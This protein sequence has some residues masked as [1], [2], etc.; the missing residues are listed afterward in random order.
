M[1]TTNTKFLNEKDNR[2]YYSKSDKQFMPI[3]HATKAHKILD[4]IAWSRENVHELGSNGHLDVGCKDGYFGL[5][6]ASEGISYLGI[7]PSEDA[8]EEATL[9]AAELGLDCVFQVAFIEDFDPGFK[10][11]TVSM[12]EVLEHVV[13]AEAVVK[14]LSSLG[15]F[16]MITTPDADGPHGMVD[17]EQNIEHVRMFTKQELSDLV[18]KYGQVIDYQVR[19]GQL[20]ILFKSNN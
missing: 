20:C 12:M 15:K 9:R 14:K 1:Q 11:D 13:D 6:L 18:S 8:I 19:D 4:R 3:Q 5:T 10:F 7:D 16:V 2:D 17:S